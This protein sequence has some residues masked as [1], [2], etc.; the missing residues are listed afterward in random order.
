LVNLILSLSFAVFA[1][2]ILARTGNDSL[3]LGSVQM[4]FGIAG[5][6]GG[7]LVGI[8]GGPKR[9]IHGL[10]LGAMVSCLFGVVVLGVGR[11]LVVWGA[12]AFVAVALTPMV[13]GA[14]H[15]IWQTK[16][17]PALQGRV[18]SARIVI[19][20]IGGALA[21][22]VGGLLADRLFEPL[23]RGS[24]ALA[25]TMTPLVGNGPGSGMGLMFVLFGLL[26][27][28]AALGGYLYRPVRD[29]ET[30]LPDAVP[31]SPNPTSDA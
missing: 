25:R 19:G 5:V 31:S 8:W 12:G 30:I 26:G 29:I 9:K 15:A 24:S 10:L 27:T 7:V 22:P 1:P 13:Q 16:V 18:F 21:L 3:I 4:I 14:S 28:L 6:L 20:Q 2:M 17:P 11:G 23:M